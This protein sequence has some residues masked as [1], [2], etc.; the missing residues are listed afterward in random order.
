[1]LSRP[2]MTTHEVAELLKVREAT[3]RKWIRDGELV[4][5]QL[6]R[7]WRVAVR[8]LEEFVAE[9]LTSDGNRRSSPED[10]DANS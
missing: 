3:V 6:H 8:H 4:A 5:I 7:E 1:M 9:R 2:L 10:T